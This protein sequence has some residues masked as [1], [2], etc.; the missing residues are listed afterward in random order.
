MIKFML[1]KE[2]TVS[3]GRGI[4]EKLLGDYGDVKRLLKRGAK[5]LA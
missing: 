2:T 4:T 3:K 5:E 1:V